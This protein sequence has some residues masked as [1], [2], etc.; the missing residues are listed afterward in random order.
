MEELI[1]MQKYSNNIKELNQIIKSHLI[2][3]C[4][5]HPPTLNSDL[6]MSIIN[7]L[8][9]LFSSIDAQF[10]ISNNFVRNILIY[11]DI[12]PYWKNSIVI[13][14]GLDNG[15]NLSQYINELTKILKLQEIIIEIKEKYIL[16]FILNICDINFSFVI[17]ERNIMSVYNSFFELNQLEYDVKNKLLLNMANNKTYGLDDSYILNIKKMNLFSIHET[18]IDD[19]EKIILEKTQNNPLIIFELI[20]LVI[21]FPNFFNNLE[22]NNFLL[23]LN[24]IIKTNIDFTAHIKNVCDG[25]EEL[26]FYKE[27]IKF[28][29]SLEEKETYHIYI[30]YMVCY[31]DIFLNIITGVKFNEEIFEL[32]DNYYLKDFLC[33]LIYLQLIYKKRKIFKINQHINTNEDD[34]LDIFMNGNDQTINSDIKNIYT[35]DSN[36]KNINEII[37]LDKHKF[38]SLKHLKEI[39]KNFVKFE[40]LIKLVPISSNDQLYIKHF[41]NINMLLYG[42]LKDIRKHHALKLAYVAKRFHFA[43]RE[44]LEKTIIIFNHLMNRKAYDKNFTINNSFIDIVSSKVLNDFIFKKNTNIPKI[45][46]NFENNIDCIDIT[47]YQDAFILFIE[48]IY[49]YKK[50]YSEHEPEL[51]DFFDSVFESKICDMR[52]YRLLKNKSRRKKEKKI[53]KIKK[54]KKEQKKNKYKIVKNNA[55]CNLG[56]AIAINENNETIDED[57]KTQDNLINKYLIPKITYQLMNI[58]K[59]FSIE[60]SSTDS[61]TYSETDSETYSNKYKISESCTNVNEQDSYVD[62]LKKYMNEKIFDEM[63]D[64]NI[65]VI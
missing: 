61:E 50:N 58:S 35:H 62:D 25:D 48:F 23:N 41:Y 10:L 5:K 57:E 59:N 6:H 60:N 52:A 65:F 8:N 27:I 42:E 45:K 47:D 46:T 39:A 28:A 43:P 13:Y 36:D 17:K 2:E 32:F 7:K 20:E 53:K 1:D 31:Y 15:H 14:V 63:D 54:N 55:F 56:E 11:G 12:S 21:N 44:L 34:L 16:K 18:N 22:V 26:I 38:K 4:F 49:K 37:L 30:Q 9:L 64:I 40:N 33:Y 24:T 19:G 29:Y 3:G 51:I